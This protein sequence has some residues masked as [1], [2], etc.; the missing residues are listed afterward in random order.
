MLFVS[1]SPVLV[2]EVKRFFVDFKA[3]F[4]D[5]LIRARQLKEDLVQLKED[6]KIVEE[7]A[8]FKTYLE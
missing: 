5:E 6:N 2:N 3:H 4:T 1:A 8:D 7:E